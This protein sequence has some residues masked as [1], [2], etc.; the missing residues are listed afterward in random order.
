MVEDFWERVTRYKA[1]GLDP[2]RW[3][4]GCAVKVDLTTV[5]YPALK[6]LRPQLE[7]WGVTLTSREDA[8]IFPRPRGGIEFERRVYNPKDPK[9]DADDLRRIKPS[10]AIS[11]V[12]VYQRNAET[13]ESFA[14][15]LRSVYSRIGEAG[16]RFTVGK[17]HSILTAYPEAEFTLFDFVSKDGSEGESDGWALA[18]N[19]TIQVIDPTDDPG[20]EAQA[21]V[22]LS[23][24]LNDLIALGAEEKLSVFPVIDAPNDE[25]YHQ[26]ESHMK[27]YCGRYGLSFRPAEKT[28]KGTLLIGAT[29]SGEASHEL[30]TFHRNLQTGM[31]IMIS[32]P[33]GDL[34]PITSYLSCLADSDYVE[35]LKEYGLT[36]EE[37]EDAKNKVVETMKKPN[38][39]IARSISRHCPNYGEKF[40]AN[41]H[42]T[43]TVDVS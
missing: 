7:Q 6:N 4:A 30:P 3:V 24:S 5:V 35:K 12:Q 31:S 17:G 11:L 21:F 19:D 8:D 10:R 23:N 36:L 29:V 22:G 2:L 28:G 18:N 20:S 9:V 14:S 15:I 38:L 26:I 25:L 33:F 42:I 43:D 27:T 32:R 40:D 41:E 16:I 34:A 13:P 39:E 1:M 37:L